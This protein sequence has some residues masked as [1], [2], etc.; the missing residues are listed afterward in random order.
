V[1]LNHLEIYFSNNNRNTIETKVDNLNLPAVEL[2]KND[3]KIIEKEDSS[4]YIRLA[5]QTKST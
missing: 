4:W 1:F 3:A 2:E 5:N